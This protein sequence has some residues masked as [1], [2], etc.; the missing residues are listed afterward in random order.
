MDREPVPLSNTLL[1]V[2]LGFDLIHQFSRD[3][4]MRSARLVLAIVVGM[5]VAKVH[6]DD[7]PQW[8]GPK[9]D[10]VW[11]EEGLLDEF[12]EGGPK[13]VWRVPVAGGYAGPAVADGKLV[14]TDYESS[15]DV[16]VANFERK[17]TSGTERVLCLNANTGDELWRH[18]YP[19]KY[20]ISYPA[21]PR[22]TPI[23]DDDKVYTLGAEGN[24]ICF[25]ADSGRIVWQKDLPRKY[26]TKA[27]I[28]GYAGH[29]LIDGQKLI[30]VA[31]GEGTHAVAFDKHTGKE[32]WHALT[33]PEQ[34]YS[35][36]TIIEAGGKRQ[37]ILVAPN[38]VTS[39]DPET[40]KTYWSVPYEATSGSIIM[41]PIKWR[42]Y[43]YVGGYDKRSL[44]LE[45]GAAEPTAEI[46]WRDK[47]K[48]GVSPINVQP[49]VDGEMMYGFD[50]SGRMFGVALPSG[51]RVW[52]TTSPVSERPAY[53]GTAFIVRQGDAGERY[54][55]FNDSGDV[56]IARLT[57]EGYEEIDR[58]H[59]IEPTNNAF[60]REV[61]WCMPAFA[62]KR[63]YVRNDTECIAVELAAE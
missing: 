60:G 9:R 24:L 39:V 26:K 38:A 32:I 56:I 16:K 44:M 48:H 25:E 27:A 61:V 59:V 22:C 6:G 23:F 28:W 15:D 46:V 17:E 40:G 7:W 42:N 21:G 4:A 37:L 41:S 55:L 34:G 12:P 29:P 5:H 35:P 30:C 49:F 14:V 31:G 62:N 45:L 1:R 13:V 50:Q 51:E 63:M 18:E 2:G 47:A 54:W 19:V 8:M 58:A 36:P 11:R 33:A 52:E 57:P 20:T 53:S 10:N 3:S 43:L